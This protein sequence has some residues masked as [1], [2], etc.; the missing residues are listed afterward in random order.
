[1]DQGARD[2]EHSIGSG[3]GERRGQRLRW[4]AIGAVAMVVCGVVGL[5]GST[6][7]TVGSGER[8]VFVPIT[9]CRL[10]DTRAGSDNVGQRQAP[11]RNNETFVTAVRGANGNC[12]LPPGAVGVSMN[13]T[14]VD[15]SASSFLV[16]YPSDGV[17]G[18]GSNLNWTARQAPVPNAVTTKL[19]SDGKVAFYNLSG[20][21][22]IIADVNGYYEDHNFDDRYYTK[23]EVDAR[24]ADEH[25]VSSGIVIPGTLTPETVYTTFNETVTTTTFGRWLVT[26]SVSVRHDCTVGG[27]SSIYYLLVD[28]APV[29][30]SAL[31][32]SNSAGGAVKLQTTLVGTTAGVVAAGTHTIG[33][34]AQCLAGVKMF[35]AFDTVSISSVTVLD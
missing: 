27:S 2:D 35:D 4:S 28:G 10:L 17:R 5:G 23:A 14:A 29:R 1:M 20:N 12:N 7:A 26:K 33:V 8:T 34:G 21:V 24:V 6:S 16:V 31:F 18:P 19:S 32:G 11:I 30:S 3:G 13:V 15:P 22:D 25:V 9:P